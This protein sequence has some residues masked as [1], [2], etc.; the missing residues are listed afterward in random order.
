MLS[1]HMH[2]GA[3][4]QYYSSIYTSSVYYYVVAYMT[5]QVYTCVVLVSLSEF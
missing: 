3:T 2:A 4:Y 1:Q 5:A